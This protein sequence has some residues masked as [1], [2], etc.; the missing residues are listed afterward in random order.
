[1]E[2]VI[3]TKENSMDGIEDQ[4]VKLVNERNEL[5]RKVTEQE[6]LITQLQETAN[7]LTR[8]E[9]EIEENPFT[10]I[11]DALTRMVTELVDAKLEQMDS[12]IERIVTDKLEEYD[13]TEAYNFNTCVE[14]IIDEYL[15]DTISEQIERTLNNATIR[16]EV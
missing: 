7:K 6:Q 13:P 8:L 5:Q 2:T 4:I 16:I 12:E 3:E 14:N 11:Q 15:G 10:G 9:R 1:M